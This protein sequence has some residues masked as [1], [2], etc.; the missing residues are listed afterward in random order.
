MQ[1]HQKKLSVCILV[2]QI[3]HNKTKKVLSPQMMLNFQLFWQII[4]VNSFL[5]LQILSYVVGNSSDGEH[6]RAIGLQKIHFHT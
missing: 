6:V 5:S 1:Y 3:N 2:T 4:S